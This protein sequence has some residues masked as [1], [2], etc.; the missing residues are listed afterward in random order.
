MQLIDS[1]VIDSIPMIME[2][3]GGA[4]RGDFTV[5]VSLDG[6]R[7]AVHEAATTSRRACFVL[8]DA[9]AA[10]QTMPFPTANS[11][12]LKRTCRERRKVGVSE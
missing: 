7:E 12:S 8:S 5:I 6:F 9:P 10:L 4:D 1:L 3:V 2:M 11:R